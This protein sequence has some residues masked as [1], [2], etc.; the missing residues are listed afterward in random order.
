[1]ASVTFVSGVFAKTDGHLSKVQAKPL[2]QRSTRL[3]APFVSPKH[4]R[5]LQTRRQQ[6]VRAGLLDFLSPQAGPK[7]D[8]RADEIVSELLDIAAGTNGGSKAQTKTREQLEELVGSASLTCPQ[9]SR[10]LCNF[11]LH[12]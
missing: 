11:D 2:A 4:Q 7:T 6:A 8:A 12:S 3:P 9:I 1:M 10:S 5:G